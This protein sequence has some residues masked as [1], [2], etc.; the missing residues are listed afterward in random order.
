[1]RFKALDIV[2]AGYELQ[3]FKRKFFI[4]FLLCKMKDNHLE[5]GSWVVNSKGTLPGK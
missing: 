4:F 2:V 3:M 5:L 1:M